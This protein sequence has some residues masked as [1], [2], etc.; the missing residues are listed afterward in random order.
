MNDLGFS[1]GLLDAI[2]KEAKRDDMMFSERAGLYAATCVL[3]DQF[4][5]HITEERNKDGYAF[6]KV[7]KYKWHIGA[8]LG[9]DI[10]NGHDKSQHFVWALGDLHTLRD[11]LTERSA[12]AD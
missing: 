5:E 1:L 6:E 12:S 9:F 11:V 2:Y 3:Y 4:R 8:A 10:D 7:L